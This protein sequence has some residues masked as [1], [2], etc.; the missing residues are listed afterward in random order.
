MRNTDRARMIHDMAER[1]FEQTEAHEEWVRSH[2][3]TWSEKRGEG[4]TVSEFY[5]PLI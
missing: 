1:L 3:S 4:H 2:G 5:D